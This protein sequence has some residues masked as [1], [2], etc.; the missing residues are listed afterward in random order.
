[1]LV[2]LV[3]LKKLKMLVLLLMR[4]QTFRAISSYVVL[5]R[6][7]CSNPASAVCT[8][9]APQHVCVCTSA[10]RRR[11]Y[12]GILVEKLA[13]HRLRICMILSTYRH[14]V[15]ALRE[16]SIFSL[17]E[18]NLSNIKA[19]REVEYQADQLLLVVY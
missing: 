18:I 4:A 14:R 11:H 6:Q 19:E 13:G 15:I 2:M 3:M 10:L 5:S 1:M 8:F 17:E 12:L 7:G 16:T 9:T